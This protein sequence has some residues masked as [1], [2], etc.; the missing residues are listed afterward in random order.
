MHGRIVVKGWRE[1]LDLNAEDVIAKLENLV[2]C[3]SVATEGSN[4]QRTRLVRQSK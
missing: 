3:S 4:G 1:A 2:V